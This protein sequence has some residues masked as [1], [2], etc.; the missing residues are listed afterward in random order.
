MQHK[1][2]NKLSAPCTSVDVFD[3]GYNNETTNNAGI[4]VAYPFRLGELQLVL[5]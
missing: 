5:D 2:K 4:A 3:W 1:I